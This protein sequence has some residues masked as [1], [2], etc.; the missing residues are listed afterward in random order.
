[1]MELD[2]Q[3]AIVTG[4]A[5]GIGF[6]ISQRLNALGAR[7]ACWDIVPPAKANGSVFAHSEIVDVT[8]LASIETALERTL[9]TLGQADILVN[10]AG[11]N[12]PTVPIQD[13]TEADWHKVIGVD[14]TGVFLCCKAVV[15]HMVSRRYGRI[16]N[17]ASIAGK[18]GNARAT[19]YSA[20]KAGVIGLTKAL[21][22]ELIKTGVLTNAVAPAMAET[23]LLAEMTKD[24]IA[25]VKSRMPMGRLANVTEIADTVAWI[26]SPRCSFTSGQV[27]DVTGG[28][29]T[30]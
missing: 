11:V 5:R 29:A 19:A 2:G 8:S 21:S 17:I 12:G 9:A 15:P 18:E 16:V 23:E 25:D 26:A 28:R 22:K 13:Y 14:L 27:F 10:N 30:Y 20:A 1:M 24:Y 4:A 3:V 7:I 6:A